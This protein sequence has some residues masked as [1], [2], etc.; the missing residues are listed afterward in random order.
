MLW[1]LFHGQFRKAFRRTSG[2]ATAKVGEFT[3]KV[4]YP[5]LRAVKKMFS[6]Y[7]FLRS[8]TGIGVT[9]PP[10]YLEPLASRYP[11]VAAP[12]PLDR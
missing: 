4:H 3:V 9:V 8:C 6:P 2:V 7:F 12:A 5:T 10:S 1:F 11:S